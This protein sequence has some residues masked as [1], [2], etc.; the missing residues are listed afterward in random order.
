MERFLQMLMAVNGGV[1]GAGAG[2]VFAA[3]ALSSLGMEGS[4]ARGP[5][6]MVAVSAGALLGTRLGVGLARGLVPRRRIT[7]RR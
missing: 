2:G 1:G 7:D 6:M 3:T 4:P 5:A